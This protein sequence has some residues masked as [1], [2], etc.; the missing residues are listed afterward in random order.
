M[1]QTIDNYV[2]A[3][4]DFTGKNYAQACAQEWREPNAN[5]AIPARLASRLE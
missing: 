5:E 1:R 3:G 2:V 4:F